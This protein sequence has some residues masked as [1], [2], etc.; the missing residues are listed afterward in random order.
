MKLSH[1][2]KDFSLIRE[3]EG[4]GEVKLQLVYEYLSIIAPSSIESERALSAANQ[5]GTKIRSS[6]ND[7]TIDCL[8]F[9]RAHFVRTGSVDA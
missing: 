2:M 9:L 4:G 8:C 1:H 5:I 6:S 7:K 3:W